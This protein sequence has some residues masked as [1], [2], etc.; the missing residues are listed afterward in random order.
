MLFPVRTPRNLNGDTQYLKKNK[1]QIPW[2]FY[3]I[4]ENLQRCFFSHQLTK[5][6]LGA[7]IVNQLVFTRVVVFRYQGQLVRVQSGCTNHHPYTN[8]GEL[9]LVHHKPLVCVIVCKLVEFIISDFQVDLFF[10]KRNVNTSREI[11]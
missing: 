3:S 1:E 2:Y 8:L 9:A 6:C 10:K 4:A 7:A 5:I 11:T